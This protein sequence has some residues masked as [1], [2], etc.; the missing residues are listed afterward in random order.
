MKIYYHSNQKGIEL[1]KKRE[2][3]KEK[4]EQKKKLH[5][6][7]NTLKDTKK[8]SNVYIIKQLEK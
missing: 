7:K 4:R 8:N 1:K 6:K 5:P 2:R 3:K